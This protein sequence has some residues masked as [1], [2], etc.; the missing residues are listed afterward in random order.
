PQFARGE[1]LPYVPPWVLRADLGGDVHVDARNAPLSAH[2]GLGA[3]YLS[4]RPLPFGQFSAPVSLFDLTGS[5]R[6]R[7]AELSFD[8]LNLLDKRY[9]AEEFSFVSNWNAS[10]TPSLIP[11]RHIVAGPPRTVLTTLSL[12]F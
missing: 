7:W 2:L 11:A 1:L 5:L 9:A 4:A 3:S 8:V 12:H 6:W 10:G